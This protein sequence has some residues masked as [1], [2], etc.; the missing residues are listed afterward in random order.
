MTDFC[1]W[2]KGKEAAKKKRK[3][4]ARIKHLE[5]RTTQSTSETNTGSR[6]RGVLI[7][8]E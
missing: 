8:A 1:Y 2:R 4:R 3:I 7:V 5:R 6:K